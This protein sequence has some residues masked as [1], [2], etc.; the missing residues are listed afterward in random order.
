MRVGTTGDFYPFSL[1]DTKT[2]GYR[3]YDIEVAQQL[4]K[5]LGVKLEFV[6][7]SWP[8]L[9]AG[10]VSDKYDI[11]LGGI[12]MTLDRMKSVAFSDTFVSLGLVPLIRKED[13]GKFRRWEDLDREGVTIAV[14]L[15]T[16][17]EL[18][19]RATFTK[20]KILAVEPPTARSYQEVLTRRADAGIN[21][22]LTYRRAA[23]NYPS[24]VVLAPERPVGALHNGIMV[25]QGDQVLLNWLNAWVRTR[26]ETGFFDKLNEKWQVPVPDQASEA[27]K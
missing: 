10:M 4:A 16:S 6:Q 21:D 12:T 9:V 13:E 19:A 14:E 23:Q 22:I 5:D 3:G 2:N 8:G 25:P 26:Q 15:G 1:R 20:A 17:S 11:A 18:I 24:L 27:A 7:T